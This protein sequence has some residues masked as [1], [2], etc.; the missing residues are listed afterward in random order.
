ML[1]FCL[2]KCFQTSPSVYIVNVVIAKVDALQ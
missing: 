1:F 2:A